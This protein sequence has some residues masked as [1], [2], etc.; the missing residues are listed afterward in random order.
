MGNT[1]ATTGHHLLQNKS[2]DTADGFPLI[3]LLATGASRNLKMTHVAAKNVGCSS[4]TD[5]KA[6][7]L[8]MTP[9][10][11]IKHGEAKLVEPPW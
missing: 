11:L 2:S 6:I 10:Q 9:K 7:L 4:K 5:I 8:K 3:E 1:E